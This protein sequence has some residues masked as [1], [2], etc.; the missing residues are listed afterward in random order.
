MSLSWQKNSAAD[1]SGT[2]SDISTFQVD[3]A[4]GT[5]VLAVN[6]TEG[7]ARTAKLWAAC[8]ENKSPSDSE[9]RHGKE[10]ATEG[11][12]EVSLHGA[13]TWQALTFPTSFPAA[14]ADLNAGEGAFEFTVTASGRTLLDFR[15]VVPAGATSTGMLYHAP[16]MRCA[17]A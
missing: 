2:W 8:F 1:L 6:E 13:G 3:A 16:V 11:W 9:N 7:K 15:L 4:T 17:D 5:V 14:F 12:L 10:L